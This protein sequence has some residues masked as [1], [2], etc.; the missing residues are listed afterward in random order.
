[1]TDSDNVKCLWKLRRFDV[2]TISTNVCLDT[3]FDLMVTDSHEKLAIMHIVKELKTARRQHSGP[4]VFSSE[5]HIFGF[6]KLLTMH[7]ENLGVVEKSMYLQYAFK[8][9]KSVRI[10]IMTRD[11]IF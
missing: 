9:V 1:M 8:R 6:V 4:R 5:N 2:T 10:L 11:T 7:R 3:L